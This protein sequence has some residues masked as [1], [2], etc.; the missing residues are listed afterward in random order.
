MACPPNRLMSSGWRAAMPSSTS[1]MWIPGTERAE[2]RRLP[3]ALR[4]NAITGRR[5][6]SLMR[7]ATRPT[8][9]WCHSASNRHT[10]WRTGPSGSRSA[11]DRRQRRALHLRFDFAALDIELVEPRGQRQ[12][13]GIRVA[14]QATNTDRHVIETS[15]GVQAR[16]DGKAEI[17]GREAGHIAPGDGQQRANARHRA[18]GANP[19][20]ALRHQHAVVGV[21]RHQVGHRAERDQVEEIRHRRHGH[22]AARIELAPHRGHHVERHPHAGQRARGETAARHIGIDDDVGGGQLGTGQMMV[23][24]QHLDAARARRGDARDARDAIVDRDDQRRRAQRREPDDLGREP[25]AELE[26]VRHEEIDV[27]ESP[28][29]Q[30]AHDQRRAGGAVGVEIADHEDAPLTMLE[31][32]LHRRFDAVQRAHR[33]QAI[34]RERQL[35]LSRTPRAA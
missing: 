34:E 13:F 11:R 8:T 27:G 7:L 16:T 28:G 4:A 19:P 24:D 35:L 25:V 29:A 15:G 12:R 30:A 31:D 14:E 21:E 20:N 2:P 1:R 33:H 32:Q 5:T 6:R 22:R 3:S 17:R 26:A 9:P 18:A 10:P 23:G